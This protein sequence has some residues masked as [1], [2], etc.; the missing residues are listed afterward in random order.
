[1]LYPSFRRKDTRL[2]RNGQRQTRRRTRFTGILSC[3]PVCEQQADAG[4]RH[5]I[6]VPPGC[7]RISRRRMVRGRSEHELRTACSP[8]NAPLC[9][10]PIFWAPH[11]LLCVRH[12]ASELEPTLHWQLT[13]YIRR[14]IKFHQHHHALSNP[15]HASLF[16]SPFFSPP[17]FQPVGTSSWFNCYPVRVR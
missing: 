16:H 13:L 2:H 1:M 17:P 14:S 6:L 3:V 11:A 15:I 10:S 12:Q 9:R 7:T 8:L 5:T 4:R